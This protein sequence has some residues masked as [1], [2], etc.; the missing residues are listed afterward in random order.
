[1]KLCSRGILLGASLENH[2]YLVEFFFRCLLH[3][4]MVTV[5]AL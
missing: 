2:I 4:I 5:I 3:Y 1:M